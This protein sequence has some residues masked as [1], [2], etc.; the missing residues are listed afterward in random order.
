VHDHAS[1]HSLH[2]MHCIMLVA[3]TCIIAIG[4]E[5]QGLE[6]PPKAAL[7]E[8]GN[9]EQDQ[10][11]PRCICPPKPRCLSG[12]RKASLRVMNESPFSRKQWLCPSL[13][14]TSQK[15]ATYGDCP[16]ETYVGRTWTSVGSVRVMLV[17]VSPAGCTSIGIVATLEYE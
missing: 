14:K 2:P 3:H 17:R 8:A 1:Y 9:H 7:V 10:G 6:E 11:K 15:V 5:K 12:E 4:P 13:L 16:Q